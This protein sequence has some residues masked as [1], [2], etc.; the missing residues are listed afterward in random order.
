MSLVAMECHN[1]SF[2]SHSSA[3]SHAISSGQTRQE[4]AKV[5]SELAE[6]DDLKVASEIAEFDDFMNGIDT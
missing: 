6:I 2:Y 5:T 3:S 4:S 1:Y